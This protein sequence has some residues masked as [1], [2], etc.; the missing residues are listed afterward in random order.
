M[1]D[2]QTVQT[3]ETELADIAAQRAN[4]EA[5]SVRKRQMTP[6]E[7]WARKSLRW[8]EGKPVCD[9][10][11]AIRILEQHPDF[12]GRFKYNEVLNKVLDKGTVMI[13][14]RVNEA[15]AVIQEGFIPAISTDCVNK[16]LVIVAN[17]CTVKP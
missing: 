8:R 16:A 10:A 4:G 11:N 2:P 5:A 12:K 1:L 14:W 15:C 6:D 3:A 9:I 17:R 7:A 13:E